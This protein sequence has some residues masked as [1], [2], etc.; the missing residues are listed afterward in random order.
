MPNSTPQ[1]YVDEIIRDLPGL[2]DNHRL[3]ASLSNE[4]PL[5]AEAAPD[6]LLSALER[7]LGGE[8]SAIKGIFNESEHLLTPH[9]AHTGL[10]WALESLAWDPALLRRATYVLA[11]LA[12]IDPGGRLTNRPINSL[13][14]IF[15]SWHPNT[16]ANLNQRLAALDYIIRRV[17]DVA[18]QLLVKLFPKGND[19]SMPSAMPRFREAGSSEQ[20]LL[21][22]GVVWESQRQIV[23]RA[24]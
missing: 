16:N 2:S 19:S 3:L 12:D 9:S 17:P 13:R 1:Q 10:L 22:N 18:W 8:G 14:M 7:M 15:L 24:L 6:P 23:S 4:L 5:L 20:E 21:T 11:R